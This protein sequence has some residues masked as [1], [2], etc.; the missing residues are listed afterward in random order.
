MAFDD[1]KRY[2]NNVL[3]SDVNNG[4]AEGAGNAW[5]TLQKG[6]DEQ[7]TAAGDLT[8]YVKNTDTDYTLTASLVFDV[9]LTNLGWLIGYTDTIDDG[10]QPTIDKTGAV[11]YLF[12]MS[13]LWN[14]ATNWD[15][16][17]FILDGADTGGVYSGQRSVFRDMEIQNCGGSGIKLGHYSWLFSIYSHNNARNY[18]IGNGC[19]LMGCYS[20]YSTTFAGFYIGS[21]CSLVECFSS[22]DA[23]YGFRGIGA[24]TMYTNCLAYGAR[25]NDGFQL[26]YRN[27]AL[28]CIAASNSGYGFRASSSMGLAVHCDAFNNGTGQYSA[29]NDEI[30]CYE[31]DPEFVDPDNHDFRVGENMQAAGFPGMVPGLHAS[32]IGYMDIGGLQ[33]K[34]L[35]SADLAAV[36]NVIEGVDRGDGEVGTYHEATE[37]EVV[38]LVGFGEDGTAKTGNVVLPAVTVVWTGTGFGADGTE[39]E[40]TLGGFPGEPSLAV[41]ADSSSQI[42]ATVDGDS[43]VTNRLYYRKSG[44]AS[45]TAGETRSGDGDITQ[46]GLTAGTSYSFVAV[47]TSA[48]GDIY[49]LPSAALNLLVTGETQKIYNIEAILDTEERGAE[50]VLLCS[51]DMD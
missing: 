42:T 5:A 47:S 33:R 14:F 30:D 19:H 43:G 49:G 34:E 44:Q 38:Y 13:A 20:Y 18:D 27:T 16:R 37:S 7:E 3:G 28:N 10:G 23:T 40:G 2:I 25:A 9:A 15:I 8:I 50:M 6:V 1:N 41:V 22:T 24:Y 11:N 45:W 46:T 12:D 51:I 36:G 32:A 35:R 26:A 31:V 4:Q 39:Y 48:V 29:L 21:S 17:N